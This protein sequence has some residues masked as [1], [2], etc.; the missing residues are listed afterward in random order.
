MRVYSAREAGLS[1]RPVKPST[2]RGR[3]H[4]FLFSGFAGVA[5][6]GGWGVWG[7]P[8]R[9][10]NIEH[11]QT[12]PALPGNNSRGR[13]SREPIPPSRTGECARERDTTQPP[14]LH[15]HPLGP[16]NK[17]GAFFAELVA[18]LASTARV[19]CAMP[20]AAAARAVRALAR[21]GAL[22]SAARCTGVA[23]LTTCD[24]RQGVLSPDH[25]DAL[26]GPGEAGVKPAQAMLAEIDAFIVQDDVV[27]LRTLRL[28]NG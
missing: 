25:G 24:H 27:P 28:V 3:S 13:P 14:A 17:S 1:P 19:V 2:G 16:A 23:G 15:D 26:R 4:L 20:G 5:P 18:C 21:G 7:T 22:A 12:V 6:R 10:N 8:Q 11:R 9:N